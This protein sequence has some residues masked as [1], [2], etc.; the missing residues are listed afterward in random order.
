VAY[1]IYEAG[2]YHDHKRL[3]LQP[4]AA[5]R[6]VYAANPDHWLNKIDFKPFQAVMP[7]PYYHVGSEN[8]WLDFDGG[9]FTRVQATAFH[10]G[11]PDMGVNMS[12]TAISKMLR[13]VQLAYEP[14]QI[15]AILDDLPDNRPIALLV[16]P[17]KWDEVQ[18]KYPHLLAYATLLYEHPELKV[19]SVRPDDIRTYA[20]SRKDTI[21]NEMRRKTL[22]KAGVWQSTVE[23]P[24]IAYQSFDSL[25]SDKVFLGKGAYTG[26]M[27]DTTHIFKVPLPKG[28][29][30][31]S[32]W[33]QVQQDMGMTQEVRI[34]EIAQN[35]GHEVHFAH[36]G[37][38]FFLR[39]IVDGWALFE[40]PFEVYDT[41]S[42]IDIYLHK[43][44]VNVP[45]TVDECLV[46]PM[47]VTLF[48]ERE[49][50]ILKD[51]MW[52]K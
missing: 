26:R 6:S 9:H 22:F 3:A 19:L 44:G 21:A 38:R 37:C 15:P 5:N 20:M 47:S 23:N 30:T 34:R 39:S 11:L 40:V 46:K 45:F 52:Y 43:A 29:F 10:T 4:N 24:P 49:G 14:G 42:M 28:M 13:S 35:D 27:D 41:N 33:V 32:M 25:A 36:E 8:I 12:R 51:N 50:G 18:R 16:H 7:L 1:L 2:Y 31:V 48:R 17:P